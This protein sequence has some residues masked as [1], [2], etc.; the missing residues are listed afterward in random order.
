MQRLLLVSKSWADKVN[1][2]WTIQK[3]CGLQLL[4]IMMLAT[5]KLP[6]MDEELYLWVSFG[7]RGVTDR[8]LIERLGCPRITKRDRKLSTV[9]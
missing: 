8:K 6:G 2:T 4:G 9:S 5:V 3:S 1:M 7:G